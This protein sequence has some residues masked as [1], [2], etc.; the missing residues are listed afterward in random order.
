MVDSKAAV[1]SSR[2]ADVTA[3]A[4]PDIKL[5]GT[6]AD[7]SATPPTA[8]ESSLIT[9]VMTLWQ[10]LRQR[11]YLQLQ[12]LTL[13]TQRAAQSLVNML[14]LALFAALLLISCWLGLLSVGVL[15]LKSAGLSTLAALGCVLLLNF[16]ALLTCLKLIRRQSS[17]LRYPASMA[18]LKP[19][20]PDTGPASDE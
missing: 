6:A 5:A 11:L 3:A 1:T 2:A 17:Y 19:K 7:V 15:L 9:A 8:S 16:L 14:I 18:L 10:G 13:E 12:L 4:M 20:A